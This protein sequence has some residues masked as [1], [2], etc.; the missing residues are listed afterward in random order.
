[1]I[2]FYVLIENNK[3]NEKEKIG[4]SRKAVKESGF[5]KIGRYNTEDSGLVN[6]VL[7]LH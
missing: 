5:I 1:M 4:G 6:T 7:L 3:C 2:L